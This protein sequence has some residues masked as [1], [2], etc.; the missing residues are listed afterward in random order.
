MGPR[1][2]Y[3]PARLKATKFLKKNGIITGFKFIKGFELWTNRFRVDLEKKT[4]E[5]V[6][7]KMKIE[8]ENRRKERNRNAI[9]VPKG[10]WEL[11]HPKIVE[12]AKSRFQANHF[13]D[14]S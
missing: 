1:G 14:S 9:R 4:F 12:V 7:D 2:E 5:Y 8:Y 10:L 3:C 6:L 11:L 13:V